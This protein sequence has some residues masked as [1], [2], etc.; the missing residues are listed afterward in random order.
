[1]ANSSDTTFKEFYIQIIFWK[2]KLSTEDPQVELILKSVLIT[3]SVQETK[4][5]SIKTLKTELILRECVR[6]CVRVFYTQEETFFCKSFSLKKPC[7]NDS[8]NVEHVWVCEYL[9]SSSF[10][11]L[12]FFPSFELAIFLQKYI[13][14][15]AVTLLLIGK[16][17]TGIVNLLAIS[18]LWKYL[19][20]FHPLRK[21][22]QNTIVWKC[23]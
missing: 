9:C 20:I 17:V 5:V 3:S 2:L 7:L 15:M 12:L 10:W 16:L 19:H 6:A 23:S 14:Y 11:N 4:T 18:I 22:C 21:Y 8:H 1:M 13:F